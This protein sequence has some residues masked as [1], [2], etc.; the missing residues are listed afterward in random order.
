MPVVFRD[1]GFRFHFY[2]NEGE[3][4]EPPHIHV[5]KDGIDAKFWLR[6]DVV[7]AYNDGFSAKTL[8]ELTEVIVRRR[9]E[10]EQAWHEFFG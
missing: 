5:L 6:P 1:K 9:D 10:I 7:V 8:R 2:S 3:P 4:R